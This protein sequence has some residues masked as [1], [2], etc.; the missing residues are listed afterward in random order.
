MATARKERPA[1]QTTLSVG[2]PIAVVV[3]AAIGL[4]VGILLGYALWGP[5]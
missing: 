5:A 2:T 1:G 3:V 4:G